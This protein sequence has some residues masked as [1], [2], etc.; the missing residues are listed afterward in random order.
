MYKG[1]SFND[2]DIGYQLLMMAKHYPNEKEIR[3][4]SVNDISTEPG[5]IGLL[6]SRNRIRKANTMRVEKMCK[7]PF[8]YQNT[9][10]AKVCINDHVNAKTGEKSREFVIKNR[11]CANCSYMPE[12][13][14]QTDKNWQF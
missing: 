6:S 8:D 14:C 12:Y 5:S 1:Y 13:F 2:S 9:H 11:Y 7:I 10:I 4:Y 3:I